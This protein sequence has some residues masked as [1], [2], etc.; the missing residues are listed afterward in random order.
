VEKFIV[1]GR[2]PL[3]GTIR[4]SGNKNAALPI[5]AA[6]LL[7][8]EE[9]V[10]DNLPDIRDV[11]HMIALLDDL[12]VTI[13]KLDEHKMVLRATTIRK[14]EP[15]ATLSRQ[16]RG[17]FLLAGPLLARCQQ[18]TL[19]PPGGDLIGRRRLDTHILAL[20]GLGARV[21]A[22]PYRYEMSSEARLQS[23][24]IFLD[25]TSVMATENAV[26]AAVTAPG[27]TLIRNAA[28]EPHVQDL[29]HCLNRMGARISG[30]GT[31]M[32]TV[33]GVDRL[34]GCQYTIGVDHTE[35]GSF[36]ALAAL[37]GN[38]LLI[39]D[40]AP[41]NLRMTLLAFGRLGIHVEVRGPDLY[42]PRH[43]RLII[44]AD[45]HGA[46]PKIE[47]SPWPGFPTDLMSVAIVVATQAEGTILLWE[48]MFEGRMFFVDKL[49]AMG[50]RIVL[51]DPFR[52]VVVGPSPLHGEEVVSPD[53]RAG[54]A[55]LIAA[56][57]AE[58]RSCIRN[59]HQIDRGYE[60][61]DERLRALGAQVER[62]KEG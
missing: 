21:E 10:L 15:D 24:D 51:C 17:S 30:I 31:N 1:E 34:H 28:S 49:L 55:L 38:G 7:T 26:M 27:T 45:Y 48:K 39:Q 25:E 54:V 8:D 52:V 61:I 29:C 57:A 43:D 19:A 9:V 40:A 22:T 53:I 5:L 13:R 33:E 6:T 56:L 14:T 20:E 62:V 35:V 50:A 42:V 46:I 11:R 18:V 44:T 2:H 58:G 36:I 32:L 60:R 3:A 41:E 59:V 37:T 16:L 12:G 4:P 47:S 23:A